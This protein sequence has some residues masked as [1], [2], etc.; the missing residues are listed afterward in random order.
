LVFVCVVLAIGLSLRRLTQY[1][2]ARRPK[3][4]LL[5]QAIMEQL[6]PEVAASRKC[7]LG[8]YGSD[9]LA[10]AALRRCKESGAALVVCF[11]RQVS[12]S[13][14]YDRPL[15]IDSDLAAQKTFAKFLDMGHEMGVPVMPVYDTGPDAALLLAETAAIYGCEKIFIGTSRQ[16]ALYHL[17]KGHF[18]QRLEALL[19]PDVPVEVIAPEA[20]PPNPPPSPP[21][22]EELDVV[23]VS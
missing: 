21:A 10:R 15:S 22:A 7:L 1:A 20:A 5:R 18:Q 8:T 19:P 4:S 12:L 23:N 2:A 3:P 11:I 13:F 9:A 17:L 14:R 16:G 6:S